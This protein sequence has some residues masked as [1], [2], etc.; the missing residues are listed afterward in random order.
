M[1]NLC[2]RAEMEKLWNRFWGQR[3]SYGSFDQ[4]T[5]TH[6]PLSRILDLGANVAPE[7]ISQMLLR[8]EYPLVYRKLLER[9]ASAERIDR[10]IRPGGAVVTGYSGGI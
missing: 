5:V 6:N 4:H 9:Y 3:V 8:A 7:G 10:S 2:D 1:F